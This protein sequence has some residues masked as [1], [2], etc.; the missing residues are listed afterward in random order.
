MDNE[1]PKLQTSGDFKILI[2]RLKLS[3]IENI[4]AI[5]YVF[6]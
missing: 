6:T 4:K 3:H 1:F 5:Y 2:Y